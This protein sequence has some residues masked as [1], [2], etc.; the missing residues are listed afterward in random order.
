MD[1][2]RAPRPSTGVPAEEAGPGGG[3]GGGARVGGPGGGGGGG[4]GTTE[5]NKNR[6][7]YL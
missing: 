6:V 1:P 2:S 4:T 7:E 5:M 3:G